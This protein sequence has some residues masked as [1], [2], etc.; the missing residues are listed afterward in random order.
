VYIRAAGGVGGIPACYDVVMKLG[1]RQHGVVPVLILFVA[2]VFAASMSVVGP[3]AWFW[4]VILGIV[5]MYVLMA[6]D[7]AVRPTWVLTDSAVIARG[8]LGLVQ[9]STPYAGPSDLRLDG[10]ELRR[11]DGKL[12]INGRVAHP[13][14]WALVTAYVRGPEARGSQPTLATLLEVVDVRRL[15]HR[16]LLWLSPVAVNVIG[17]AIALSL[18][19]A[20]AGARVGIGVLIASNVLAAVASL[21]VVRRGVTLVRGGETRDRLEGVVTIQAGAFQLVLSGMLGWLGVTAY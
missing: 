2:V 13:G 19:L 9:R 4:P 15:V 21:N 11:G 1:V 10:L 6:I 14:D 5:V 3:S 16:L 20:G 8:A 17:G 12:L 7:R 18:S